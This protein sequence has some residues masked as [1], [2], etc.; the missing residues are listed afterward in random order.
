MD[1]TLERRDFET[2]VFANGNLLATLT[3]FQPISDHGSR[4]RKAVVVKNDDNKME[5][6]PAVK[7]E[8]EITEEELQA[9]LNA[10]GKMENFY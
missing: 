9:T 7:E 5:V 10:A 8:V 6:E 2:D 3:L 4:K 1:D